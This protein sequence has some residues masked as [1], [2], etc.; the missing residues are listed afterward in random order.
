MNRVRKVLLIA[1][2]SLSMGNYIN[3]QIFP[4]YFA[5]VI[6]EDGKELLHCTLFITAVDT[7]GESSETVE[8]DLRKDYS[9]L[10]ASGPT[11][12]I[13]IKK[14]SGENARFVGAQSEKEF[15]AKGVN[16]CGIRLADHDSFEP[17]I[18]ATQAH[19]ERAIRVNSSPASALVHGRMERC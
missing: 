5:D 14:Q 8:V 7:Q 9:S 2:L 17:D 15:I 16:F 18:I 13:V 1:L 19:V 4:V 3:A 11:E 6:K 12:Q 10:Y